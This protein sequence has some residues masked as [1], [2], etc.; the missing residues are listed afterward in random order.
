MQKSGNCALMFDVYHHIVKVGCFCHLQVCRHPVTE[1]EAKPNFQVDGSCNSS[2][3][4]LDHIR[5]YPIRQLH[6][7]DYKL[8]HPALQF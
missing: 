5:T 4:N 1:N 6:F 3:N 8:Q 7:D 2:H